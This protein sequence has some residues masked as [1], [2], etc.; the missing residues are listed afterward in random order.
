[1]EHNVHN[2]LNFTL[3]VD[4]LIYKSL[5]EQGSFVFLCFEQSFAEPI[6]GTAVCSIRVVDAALIT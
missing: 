2:V 5:T 1:M 6:P 4:I 3:T